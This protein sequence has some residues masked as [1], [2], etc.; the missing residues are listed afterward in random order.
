MSEPVAA[1]IREVLARPKFARVLTPIRQAEIAALLFSDA[2][3]F[4]P[5]ERVADC[6]DPNDDKYLE[7]AL[8][9]RAT[10]LI[11]SDRDLLSLGL[12]RG[13]RILNP[14]DYLIL[15]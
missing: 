6:R 8:A 12:W 2:R 14:S 9:A 3:W 7:L 1:E 15:P 5:V 11:S 13:T 4:S 10:E